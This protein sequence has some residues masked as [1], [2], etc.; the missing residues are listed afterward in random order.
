MPK[1]HM[2]EPA[3]LCNAVQIPACLL[4]PTSQPALAAQDEPRWEGWYQSAQGI[5]SATWEAAAC[6]PPLE[7]H[8]L[9]G[10]VLQTTPVAHK[11]L[12]IKTFQ[13]EIL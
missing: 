6:C 2:N 12:L 4:H 5:L 7:G 13:E 11:W 10:M 8:F 1:L 9:P 3:L